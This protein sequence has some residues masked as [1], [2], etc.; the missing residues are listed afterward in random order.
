MASRLGVAKSTVEQDIKVIERWWAQSSIEQRAALIKQESRKLDEL[1]ASWMERAFFDPVA[2]DN[3]LRIMN[4]RAKMHGLYAPVQTELTIGL[5]VEELRARAREI[6]TEDL[7][8][9]RELDARAGA[10][11]VAST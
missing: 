1:E 7:A 2:L 6:V 5:S 8:R 4:A 9:R 3:V 11:D 10:I